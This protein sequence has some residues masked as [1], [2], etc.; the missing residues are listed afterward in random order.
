MGFAGSVIAY[1]IIFK[2]TYN[3][4]RREKCVSERM[5]RRMLVI[6]PQVIRRKILQEERFRSMLCA[7]W[8]WYVQV[9]EKLFCCRTEMLAMGL[10]AGY[11]GRNAGVL[12]ACI[13]LGLSVHAPTMLE[14]RV[15]T[16]AVF[17][18]C[19]PHLSMLTR[20]AA[21]AYGFAN[22][23][24]PPRRSKA[25]QLMPYRNSRKTFT[26]CSPGCGSCSS[27]TAGQP[28]ASQAAVTVRSES[29]HLHVGNADA[30]AGPQTQALDK[31]SGHIMDTNMNGACA[32]HAA[33]G[34]PNEMRE[35]FHANARE[36][37]Q[38]LLHEP[39]HAVRRKVSSHASSR[40]ALQDIET[41]IWDELA[42]PSL[43][44]EPEDPPI[45]NEQRIF[46][47]IFLAD[48]TMRS[49]VLRC[50]EHYGVQRKGTEVQQVMLEHARVLFR[51][52]YWNCVWQPL[53][54]Q[55]N[56][57]MQPVQYERLF[58]PSV[59]N[60][61]NRNA[62]LCALCGSSDFRELPSM[63]LQSNLRTE[64]ELS[65]ALQEEL[66]KFATD[67]L[68]RYNDV[69]PQSGAPTGFIEEVWPCFVKALGSDGYWLSPEELL[70]LCTVAR[71]SVAIFKDE[72]HQAM[73]LSSVEFE[74]V[75]VYP[76]LLQLHGD[77]RGHFSRLAISSNLD[78]PAG[79]IAPGVDHRSM[80]GDM[81][82]H[83]SM[84]SMISTCS[85]QD[86]APDAGPN[87]A[88]EATVPKSI[89]ASKGTTENSVR[90]SMQ[91]ELKQ[92]DGR[93]QC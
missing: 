10:L 78:H 93:K 23:L 16:G 72:G 18:S 39:I 3:Q 17:Y 46:A 80:E 37:I 62:F 45:T 28:D 9:D 49:C 84:S 4:M 29:F 11:T 87:D 92:D 59:E 40:Q 57:H 19:C 68:S 70:V 81:E 86:G 7:T 90:G 91:L 51:P 77:R 50:R 89:R 56:V 36:M 55:R 34:Q 42:L 6:S 15:W 54:L 76:V 31:T 53:A 13:L 14:C 32:I 88:H 83:Q 44:G 75:P 27:D 67:I 64:H 48:P 35:L 21:C 25:T 22:P 63:L 43:R 65:V 20:L 61:K 12:T 74:G 52:E 33:F 58:D 8:S 79:T 24:F 66:N 26:A 41:S 71:R 82:V 69:E 30:E 2:A 85:V 60:D 5:R 73:L 38:C 1:F 47:A